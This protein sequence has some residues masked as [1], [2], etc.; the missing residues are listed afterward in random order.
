[1]NGPHAFRR[2]MGRR[3][4]EAGVPSPMICDVLGHASADSLRQYTASSLE[5]LK[6][7]ART[8]EDILVMQEELL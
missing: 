6:Q 5:C 7:C 3:L 8:M 1:M 2:G 4:L